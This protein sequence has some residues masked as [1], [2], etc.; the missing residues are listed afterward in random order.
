M[1]HA[2]RDVADV[3]RTLAQVFVIDLGKRLDV[4]L[5]DFVEAGLDIHPARFE[6]ADRLRDQRL[7]FQHQQM[8]VKNPRL[9]RPEI[10]VHLRH[11]FL[12]LLPR[13]QNRVIE[14]CDLLHALVG[15]DPVGRHYHI[16]LDIQKRL[17]IREAL[18][19]GDALHKGFGFIAFIRGHSE[20]PFWPG[21][22]RDFKR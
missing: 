9:F 21:Q 5:R 16:A 22:A 11:D 7:V 1:Q 20:C 12:D 10:L 8:R 17:A 3:P 15:L 2:L 4:A 19:G 18:R 13:D 14:A 6:F